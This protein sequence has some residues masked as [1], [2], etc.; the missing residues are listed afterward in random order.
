MAALTQARIFIFWLPL[1]AS[2]LLMTAE[3]PILSAVV[4][5]LPNEVVMLAALGIV[6]AVE[7]TIESPVINLL[8][9]STALVRDRPSFLVVRRFT[10]HW[11]VFLTVL[12]TAVAFT[13]LFGWVVKDLLGTPPEVA[14]WVQPGLQIMVPWTPAIAWRRFLQGVL[15]RFGKTRTIAVGTALR[16]A[17]TAGTALGL[18][19]WSSLPGIHIF[20]WALLAGVLVEAAYATAVAQEVIR[21]LDPESERPLS[22]RRLWD[23][24]LPLAMTAA[25]TLASQP[26]VTFTLARLSEPTLTLAAWPLVF[27]ALLFLRAAALALPEMVIALAERP[28]ALPL[29]RAFSRRLTVGVSLFTVLLVATPLLQLYLFGL[30]DADPLVGDRAWWGLALAAPLPALAVV[31]AWFQGL[32][33]ARE[34][35]QAVNH[36]TALKLA[37]LAGVLAAGLWFDAP[38]LPTAVIA[39]QISTVAQGIFMASR[40]ADRR[41]ETV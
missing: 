41:A 34:K 19:A 8:S 10:L 36:A 5:R 39:M 28:G 16:L 25:L 1:F 7:V 30:Q 40:L 20:A 9:T 22:Y 33:I 27:Q 29:L 14:R 4:N 21:D 24:H 2:W 35:T 17:A 32:L 12:A 11:M 37:V 23:F 15:I 31:V 38:G 13:P 3:G 6:F 18:A 26:L